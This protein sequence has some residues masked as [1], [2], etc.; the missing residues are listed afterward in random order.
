MCKTT[1]LFYLLLQQHKKILLS[2]AFFPLFISSPG[3]TQTQIDADGTLQSNVNN[4]GNGLY[5]ITGGTRPNNGTNLFHS[6]GNFSVEI[7][8]TARF[9]HD[10]GVE[11][12]ITRITGGSPSNIDGTI[13]TLIDE[14]RTQA[15]SANLF[16]INPQGIIFGPNATLDIGGSLIGST[17]DSIKFADGTI[18]S[19]SKPNPVLSI[20]VPIGLQYGAEPGNIIVEGTGNRTGFTDPSI[21]DYSLR[22]KSRPPGLQVSE[23]K[24]LALI[25]GNIALD[26]GESDRSRR[27]Y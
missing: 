7:G 27:T 2:F 18:F 26:G 9:V 17:A 21:N 6:L 14:T 8:D 25:G 3:L 23:G 20:D 16:L 10:A 12:I 19:A 11:N 5:S 24:T 1:T 22:K 15:S 4:L 13:Q